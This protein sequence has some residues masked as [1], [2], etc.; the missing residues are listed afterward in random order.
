MTQITLFYHFVENFTPK[1]A[2]LLH[3]QE[4]LSLTTFAQI[5]NFQLFIKITHEKNFMMLLISSYE[6]LLIF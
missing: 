2:Y 3:K 6:R 1:Q 5:T 4:I